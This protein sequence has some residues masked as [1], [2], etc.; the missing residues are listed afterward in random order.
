MQSVWDQSLGRNWNG[1]DLQGTTN[2]KSLANAVNATYKGDNNVY[3]ASDTA[4][5][6]QAFRDIATSITFFAA[7][8]VTITDPL[9]DYA[10]IVLNG[11]GV[12]EFTITV[13]N[14]KGDTWKGTVASG[15]NLTFKG[16]EK[17]D[18]TVTATYNEETKTI[19]L[20][21]PDNYGLEEGYTYSVSTVIKPSAVAVFK[22]HEFHR[23]TAD[24][25]S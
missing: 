21:F 5:L 23:S 16:S 25:G 1:N 2:L 9:S 24:S 7:E 18:I 20:D 4:S 10:D 22:R 17:E 11:N 3:S 8:N 19:T 6:E 12:A 14:G 15:G 13:T